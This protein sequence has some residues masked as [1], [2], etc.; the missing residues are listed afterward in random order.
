MRRTDGG[1]EGVKAVDLVDDWTKDERWV[2]GHSVEVWAFILDEFPECLFGESLGGC[3][4][5]YEHQQV[6]K[7]YLGTCLH[8]V[9]L[10]PSPH[11]HRHCTRSSPSR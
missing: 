5:A 6:I 9:R 3:L 4:S 1:I 10:V 2:D 7:A 11:R 8:L